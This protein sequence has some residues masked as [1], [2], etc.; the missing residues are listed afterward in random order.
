MG[1]DSKQSKEKR[2][3]KQSSHAQQPP[4]VMGSSLATA[5]RPN[6]DKHHALL[7]AIWNVNR[8]LM[9]NEK[10]KELR[11][12]VETKG[13]DV[14]TMCDI[15]HEQTCQPIAQ[16]PPLIIACFEGDADIIKYLISIGADPNLTESEHHLTPIHIICDAEYHGQTIQ[17]RD[18]AEILR[19][20]LKKSANPNHL[21]RSN[22]A[23]I[24]KAVIHDRPDC[25]AAL[26][27]AKADSNASFLGDTP[28]SI[29]ARHNRKK[30]VDLLLSH[31]GT[32]VNMK[33][34]QGGTA[35]H[36]AAAA[37]VDS[38]ECVETLIRH[39]AKVNSSDNRDN[40]PA[41]VAAF[42]NK[43]RILTT[44]IK[45]GSDITVKNKEDKD[46]YSI[47]NDKDYD[48]CA[49][50]AA[51]YL[52]KKGIKVDDLTKQMKDTKITK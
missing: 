42:F 40:T 2:T 48:E 25:V 45:A 51:K 34:D 13:Q 31:K 33:N 52:A 32:N 21:D 9:P 10:L 47:A 29:A 17:Q 20:L 39:N 27:D 46:V 24:H 41:M 14:N 11:E 6:K 49:E 12:L 26:L 15:L 37:I 28:L 18:R 8:Q 4:E 23:A 19:S 44:L 30:I 16:A 5:Y 35:L 22:M 7:R 43:P 38:T 1:S 36:F 3:S 50:I